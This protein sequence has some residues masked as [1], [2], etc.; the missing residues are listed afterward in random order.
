LRYDPAV[1]PDP[2]EWL[3]LDEGEQ[4]AIVADYHRRA[5]IDLPNANLHAMIH[6]VVEQ[7]LAGQLPPVVSAFDRL[8]REGLDRHDTVHALGSVLAEHLRQLMIG[9]LDETNP[10]A[11]YFAALERL[12]AA[13]W[14]SEFGPGDDAV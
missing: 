9:A 6:T 12:T 1:S 2:A 11:S 14:V 3:A 7:Q 8:Q 4:I 13:S 5:Q 10:N